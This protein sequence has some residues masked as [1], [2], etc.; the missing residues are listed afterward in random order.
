[1]DGELFHW[2]LEVLSFLDGAET[3]AGGGSGSFAD[4]GGGMAAAFVIERWCSSGG[5]RHDDDVDVFLA[6]EGKRNNK[7][8]RERSVGSLFVSYYL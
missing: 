3:G 6:E 4:L 7:W 8:M 2:T 1:L 5:G